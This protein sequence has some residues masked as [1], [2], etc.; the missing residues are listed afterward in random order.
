VTGRTRQIL[1]RFPAHMN[2]AAEGKRFSEVTD[3]LASDLDVLSVALG[4]VR[5]S[6]RL[7]EAEEFRDLMRIGALHGIVS[8]E[9]AILLS[10]FEL[11]NKSLGDAAGSDA[12]AEALLALWGLAQPAPR[13]PKFANRAAAV[14]AARQASTSKTVLDG[15]RTRI[16]NI[17]A[18]HAVGNGTVGALL[19]GAANA[20]DLD[21]QSVAHSVDRYLH[22]AQVQDRFRLADLAPAKEHLLVEE[23]P[24]TPAQTGDIGRKNAELFSVL[25]RGFDRQTLEVKI[26][27]VESRTVG[28]MLVNRD[29]GHGV[30][31]SGAVGN[32]ATVDFTEEGRVLIDSSD[33]TSMAYAWKGA[34]FADAAAIR[35]T[36]FAFDD[37]RSVFAV[38][39][40][41]GALSPDFVFPHAGDSLPMPGIGIGETRFAFFVQ[42]AHFSKATQRVAPRPAIGFVENSVFA[43]GPSTSKPFAATVRLAWEEHQAF[44]V[45]VWIPERFTGLTP[46]DP[47]GLDTLRRVEFAVER[48]R[49]AGVQVKALFLDDR[50]TLGRGLALSADNAD[51]EA[52]GPGTGT[53]LWS[54]PSE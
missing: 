49:P 34:C 33:V 12:A 22:T 51:S 9:L 29:E 45:N 54:S 24:L 18:I 3:A 36:D 17:C 13:L 11:A 10:R 52:V 5:R 26:T 20:L 43:P 46:D 21:I 47:D 48:F 19:N 39:S 40:P 7:L 15:V 14:D 53:V 50:W 30:G 8:A 1:S 37:T 41:A 35:P 32:G 6:R 27:G 44:R 4:R 42:E 16:R 23:N 38:S 2:A 31:Y 25:R 28:P